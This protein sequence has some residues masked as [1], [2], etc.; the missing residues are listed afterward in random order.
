MNRLAILPFA[1][2]LLLAPAACGSAQTTSAAPLVL[3]RTIPLPHVSGRID[4]LA[5]D[6]DARRLFVAELGNGSV[7]AVDLASGAAARIDGLKEPQGIAYLPALR[8]LVVAC[9]GDGT[10]RFYDGRTF[11]P[12]ATLQLGDDADNVRSMPRAAWWRS[13]TARARSR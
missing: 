4:H 8:E 6:P 7:D 13:A 2:A 9:G 5:Y 10:V 11:H 12:V 3:E 1:A